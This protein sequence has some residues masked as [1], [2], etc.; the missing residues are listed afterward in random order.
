MH[1]EE[2]AEGMLF[3]IEAL[4]VATGVE[5]GDLLSVVKQKQ[6]LSEVYLTNIDYFGEKQYDPAD[7]P[8]KFA[9]EAREAVNSILGDAD[10]ANYHRARAIARVGKTELV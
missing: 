8:A 10:K 4:K 2:A 6:D 1:R 3:N 9:I 7:R 5:S